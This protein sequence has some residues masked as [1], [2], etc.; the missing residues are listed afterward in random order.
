MISITSVRAFWQSICWLVV[1][2]GLLFMAI[3]VQADEIGQV[4]Q[5]SGFADVTAADQPARPL[6]IGDK[7]A[8]QDIIRTKARSYLVVQMQDG[9]RLS[10]GENTR[11]VIAEYVTGD[12][13]SGQ[14]ELLRGRVRAIVS[15]LFSKRRNS[16]KMRTTTAVVGVQ[17]TDFSVIAQALATKIYV[18][19]GIVTVSSTDPAISLTQTLYR[20]QATIVRDQ[21]PPAPPILFSLPPAAI[22]IGS[23]S[24]QNIRSEHEVSAD[25]ANLIPVVP[26]IPL[27]LP[28][29]PA[30]PPH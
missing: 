23:G 7:L 29:V 1:G 22:P 25:P 13:P 26:T 11:L 17:G 3:P 27:P 2:G 21:Q 10:L 9:S 30:P 12:E 8:A 6:S 14:F 5:L 28:P 18:M 16:F 20:H 4:V 15:S 19:Q 24:L